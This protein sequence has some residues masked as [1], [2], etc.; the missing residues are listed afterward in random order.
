MFFFG[1]PTLLFF[2]LFLVKSNYYNG[3]GASL[4]AR[5]SLITLNLLINIKFW[6][7]C[8]EIGEWQKERV[9][10]KYQGDIAKDPEKIVI[11]AAVKFAVPI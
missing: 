1:F 3:T 2:L 10:E 11:A 4:G 5:F 9:A 8:T 7:N 6:N